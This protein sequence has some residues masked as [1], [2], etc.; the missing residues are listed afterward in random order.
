MVNSEAR[1]YLISSKENSGFLEK[2][3]S[4][5]RLSRNLPKMNSSDSSTTLLL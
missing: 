1:R 2:A 3:N 5:E 4:L